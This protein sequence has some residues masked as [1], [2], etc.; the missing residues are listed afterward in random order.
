MVHI[1]FFQ[2]PGSSNFTLRTTAWGSALSHGTVTGA[3]TC[4]LLMVG[5]PMTPLKITASS[6]VPNAPPCTA[7]SAGWCKFPCALLSAARVLR[8]LWPRVLR[9]F[10]WPSALADSLRL[11]WCHRLRLPRAGVEAVEPSRTRASARAAHASTAALRSAYLGT[12]LEPDRVHYDPALWQYLF[13]AYSPMGLDLAR[14]VRRSRHLV[15]VPASP[16]PRAQR[17]A[18]YG[19][20]RTYVLLP[21]QQASGVLIS[22][23]DFSSGFFFVDRFANGRNKTNCEEVSTTGCRKLKAAGKAAKCF[24]CKPLLLQP[25]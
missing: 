8:R 24:I 10:L 5:G 16:L 9:R 3:D 12:Q 7:L 19:K 17:F 23:F 20:T 22:G 4:E 1:E 13:H 2:E 6:R 25:E 14:L 11:C 15:S 21:V 18:T